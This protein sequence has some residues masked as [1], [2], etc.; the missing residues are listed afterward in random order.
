MEKCD[1]SLN[2]EI[3]QKLTIEEK[4]D[5]FNQILDAIIY[6]HERNDPIIHRD[7]KPGNILLKD[8]VIKVADFG[9]AFIDDEKPRVTA[10]REKVGPQ[11]FMAP[12]MESTKLTN[13]KLL[14]TPQLDVYSL[15]KIL[16][17]I[18]S[19]GKILFRESWAKRD[20]YL[21]FKQLDPR[22]LVFTDV[23]LWS[24][25]E[26]VST[27]FKSVREFKETLNEKVE[28]FHN[29]PDLIESLIELG[30]TLDSY[31]RKSDFPI[32]LQKALKLNPDNGYANYHYGLYLWRK[33][34]EYF[35]YFDKV[36]E[37]ARLGKFT[38][39]EVLGGILQ[40]YHISRNKTKE[41]IDRIQTIYEL[42]T[43]FEKVGYPVKVLNSVN[44]SRKYTI[45][46]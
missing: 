31:Q 24:I 27:R 5:L 33:K 3:L 23:F 17:Y 21:H 42:C 14:I 32:C 6:L 10:T 12:E 26:E 13:I 9:I 8:G 4:F 34:R 41:D 11:Y 29:Y 15:G 30:Y 28:E 18:L 16:Y 44:I 38:D 1:D 7:I 36:I 43:I 35:K 2:E 46:I 37:Q 22:Y 25:N 45:F 20:N 40:N 19:N 39:Y